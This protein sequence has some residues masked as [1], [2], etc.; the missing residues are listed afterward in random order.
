MRSGIELSQFLRIF[1]PT[2]YRDAT[3]S[4]SLIYRSSSRIPFEIH[5]FTTQA[6]FDME[7]KRLSETYY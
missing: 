4:P 2:F 1:L 5:T 7:K 6:V 3:D